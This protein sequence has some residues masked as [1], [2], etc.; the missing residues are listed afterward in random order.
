MA[1]ALKSAQ[2]QT[3]SE[4]NYD[5]LVVDNDSTPDSETQRLVEKMRSPNLRYIKNEQNLGGYGNWNRGFQLAQTEWICLLHDDDLLLPQYVERAYYILRKFN[6]NQLGAVL[7][8]QCNLYDDPK[9]EEME[10][11]ERDKNWKSRLDHALRDKT[12]SRVW[13]VSLFDNYML[14]SV[15]P[16][17]SGGNLLRRSAVLD[18]GGFGTKWPCED[19]FFLNRLA[20]KYDCLLLGEQWG[21]YRFGTNNMWAR[22]EDLVKLDEAKNIFREHVAL[23]DK[24]SRLYHQHFGIAMCFFDRDESIRFA[25]R[26]GMKIEPEKYVWLSNRSV[27]KLRLS[28]CR[29]NRNLWRIWLSIRIIL[30]GKRIDD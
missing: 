20:Q 3:V 16:N 14:C 1:C 28:L 11:A 4:E 2:S 13:K 15:Y 9:E 30:F 10:K 24:R 6:S 18:V 27:S 23:Y 8:R 21:W 12:A 29:I 5:I 7:S 26:R 19:I 25:H 22:P 17:I